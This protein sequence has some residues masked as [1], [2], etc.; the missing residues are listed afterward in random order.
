MN[1]SFFQ[2]LFISASCDPGGYLARRQKE[3]KEKRSFNGSK[4]RFKVIKY[5]TITE[6]DTR[7]GMRKLFLC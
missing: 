3:K 6:G 2:F 1:D 4:L 5:T 7:I